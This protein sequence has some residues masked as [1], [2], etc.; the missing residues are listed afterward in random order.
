M[1]QLATLFGSL[2]A[3]AES[4]GIKVREDRLGA[5]TAGRFDGLSVTMNRTYDPQERCFYLAHAVG[6][7]A[8][9]SLNPSASQAMFDELRAARADREADPGR[10]ERAIEAFRAFEEEASQYAVW[11]LA[12]LG[13]RG[14]VPDYTVFARA[15]VEAMTHFHR[16][17]V[18][19]RWTEFFAEWKRAVA[20]GERRVKPYQ[21]KPIPTF[22]PVPMASQE[23][24]QEQDGQP[25]SGSPED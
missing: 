1:T 10:L 12:D 7:I 9:Y 25:P 23:V 8:A 18:A 15:D 11:L 4:Y 21:R 5:E 17:G 22:Q 19:P 6:S 16:E 14:I 24:I 2:C 13:Y 3:R 20:A